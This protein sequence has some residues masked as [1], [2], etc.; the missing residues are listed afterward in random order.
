[1]KKITAI[2]LAAL[3]LCALV[4]PMAAADRNPHA[5]IVTYSP[6]ARYDIRADWEFCLTVRASSPDP[7]GTISYQW[8]QA[9]ERNGSGDL[10]FRAIPGETGDKYIKYA[11][12]D[13]FTTQEASTWYTCKIT[14]TYTENG[15]TKSVSVRTPETEVH[16]FLCFVDSFQHWMVNPLGRSLPQSLSVPLR[17]F[18]NM[19]WQLVTY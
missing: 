7:G 14:N 6:V 11:R 18:G 2:V 15:K 12:L 1:M 19:L 8:Y 4:A 17:G 3:V 10:V 16:F 9:T 5:P 13:K